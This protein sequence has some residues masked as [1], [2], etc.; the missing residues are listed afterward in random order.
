MVQLEIDY[1]KLTDE[2]IELPR[3]DIIII[4]KKYTG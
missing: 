1:E 3:E 2:I 4:T